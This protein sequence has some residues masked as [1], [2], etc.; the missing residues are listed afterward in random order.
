MDRAHGVIAR[1]R[2]GATAAVALAIACGACGSGA[3]V[4]GRPLAAGQVARS[5]PSGLRVR[6][7]AATGV[8][9]YAVAVDA[10]G[11]R[12]ISV[13]LSTRFEL[14]VRRLGKKGQ[15]VATARTVLG[16]PEWDVRDLA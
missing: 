12:L 10:A 15:V 3:P 11:K 2:R 5:A 14:V 13:E 16:P 1:G 4:R 6:Q 8:L 9:A 7:R